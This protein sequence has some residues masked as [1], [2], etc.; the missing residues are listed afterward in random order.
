LG[1]VGRGQSQR[2]AQLLNSVL[3]WGLPLAALQRADGAYAQT[4]A[5]GQR[6]L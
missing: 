4:R 3:I 6:L 1:L 5:L 2:R